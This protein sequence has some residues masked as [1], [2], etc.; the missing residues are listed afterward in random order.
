MH[1]KVGAGECSK[2][3]P[4]PATAHWHFQPI[5]ATTSSI[6]RD[7]RQNYGMRTLVRLLAGAAV[8]GLLLACGDGALDPDLVTCSFVLRA[9][10][11]SVTL[12]VGGV[13]TVIV[14]SSGCGATRTTAVAWVSS[15]TAIARVAA[16]GDSLGVVTGRAIGSATITATASAKTTTVPV[17]VQ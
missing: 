9:T 12:A 7:P 10:P 16:L 8:A 4:V 11:S 5:F 14:Q 3:N 1:S 6:L 17:T 2:G 15:D 13:D